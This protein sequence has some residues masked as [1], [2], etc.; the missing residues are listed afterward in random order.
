MKRVV[1][2]KYIFGMITLFVI[3]PASL[4]FLMLY[5]IGANDVTIAMCLFLGF[6]AIVGGPYAYYSNQENASIVFENGQIINYMND[7]TLNF[8]WAEE[9]QKI[10]RIELSNGEKAKSFFKNCKAKRVLLIDFGSHNIKYISVDLFTNNQIN[11]ILK[12]IE[13][14]K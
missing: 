11:Q 8:G 6:L 9:I 2:L 12:Y 4:I 1:P 7:G 3:V 10:K 14:N 13:N 5:A